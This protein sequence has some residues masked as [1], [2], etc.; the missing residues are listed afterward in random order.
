MKMKNIIFT[1][2][3]LTIF[4]VMIGSCNS[5]KNKTADVETSLKDTVI[6]GQELFVRIVP[7]VME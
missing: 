4:V 5:N 3:T 6:T 1:L 2:F 7:D